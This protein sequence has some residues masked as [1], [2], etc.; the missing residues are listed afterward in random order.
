MSNQEDQK[1]RIFLVGK[2]IGRIT[3]VLKVIKMTQIKLL[4]DKK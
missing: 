4:N 3:E 1:K 2:R